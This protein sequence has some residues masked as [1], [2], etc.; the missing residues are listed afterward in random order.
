MFKK[1]ELMEYFVQ[2]LPLR[3]EISEFATP[4]S[5]KQIHTKL[6]TAQEND[7]LTR[8]ENGKF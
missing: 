8:V 2:S 3:F 1:V 6:L 7:K 4:I 5:Y